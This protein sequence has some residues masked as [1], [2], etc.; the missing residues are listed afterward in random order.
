MKSM[1]D[2][3]DSRR[4]PE[5]GLE[6][7][8]KV[9]DILTGVKEEMDL[10]RKL[11]SYMT[12]INFTPEEALH[13]WDRIFQ[14]RNELKQRLAR[15]VDLSVALADYFTHTFKPPTSPLVLAKSRI[16][17]LQ[18]HATNDFLTG[19]Y[20]RYFFD[21]FINK[22]IARAGR[23]K[24]SFSLI[25]LDINNFKY[26]ND[27]YGHQK[28]DKVLEVFATT[29]RDILR[30]QDIA[31]RYGG[32]EFVCILPNT[33]YF[34]ALATTERIRRRI[35][36]LSAPLELE[37]KLSIAYGLATF[38]WDGQTPDDL[39]RSCDR[40]LYEHK[41]DIMLRKHPDRRLHQRIKTP[42][43][44]ASLCGNHKEIE[45]EV[46]DIGTE[47]IGLKAAYPLDPGKIYRAELHLGP[48]LGHGQAELEVIYLQE[49]FGS[50]RIGGRIRDISFAGQPE[51]SRS[52]TGGDS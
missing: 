15:E 45:L 12:D 28:G 22:E 33:G 42:G 4:P 23:Q 3:N 14:H 26:V 46:L 27:T 18:A 35:G 10:L 29:I 24:I 6:R 47:G 25:L 30:E 11:L 9:F 52:T 1:I 37:I 44:R 51:G 31:C 34:H 17:K 21:D 41:T 38:P 50:Y 32:D 19:I 16:A 7:L 20:N 48:P 40:R 8:D 2:P 5:V 43:D 49:S 13:Q 36:D 39:I